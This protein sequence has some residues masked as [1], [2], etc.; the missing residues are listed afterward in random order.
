MNLFFFSRCFCNV[1]LCDPVDCSI[2]GFSV[3]GDS[4]GK[5]SGACCHALLRGGGGGWSFQP[6]D[7]IQSPALQE[8]LYHLSYQVSPRVLEW[9]T[10]PF[11]RGLSWS[12]N[13]TRVSCIAGGFF[14]SWAPR[15]AFCCYNNNK[16][17]MHQ[18][19]LVTKLKLC[20]WF[21]MTMCGWGR[22][23]EKKMAIHSSIHAWEIP[24]TEE[25]GGLQFMGSNELDM[26]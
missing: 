4:P 10:Y 20:L 21:K 3:Y 23:L 15:E 2:P 8:I 17:W 24:W 9:V 18:H 12:R 14:A 5:N 11:S 7:Q 25:T 26:T 19:I 16:K 22:S 13:W 6:R 1:W